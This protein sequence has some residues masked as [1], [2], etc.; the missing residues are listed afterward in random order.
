MRIIY[1]DTMQSN[2]VYM[3]DNFISYIRD[4]LP[5][6]VEYEYGIKR[7]QRHLIEEKLN[8]FLYN[9]GRFEIGNTA[10]HLHGIANNCKY[11]VYFRP[12]KKKDLQN[13]AFIN[14]NTG[15]NGELYINVEDYNGQIISKKYK[16]TEY[17]IKRS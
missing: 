8:Y 17:G 14:I 1:D 15:L 9:N 2:F 6:F 5:E 7:V 4:I 16:I 3:I 13:C 10:T 12:V 11:P